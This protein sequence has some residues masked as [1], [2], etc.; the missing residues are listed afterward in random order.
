MRTIQ[1]KN[2]MT[3]F[4]FQWMSIGKTILYTL[5]LVN[6]RRRQ[7]TW[8]DI[9]ISTIKLHCLRFSSSLSI[10]SITETHSYVMLIIRSFSFP[11]VFLLFAFFIRFCLPF[12]IHLFGIW[13][14]LTRTLSS[15]YN[16][17]A[18]Q[19]SFVIRCR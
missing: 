12:S 5:N 13:F 14:K 6:R 8:H 15:Q 2:P 19:R 4:H 1:S 16:G 9:F 18:V 17:S 7:V 3:L 10:H 11:F